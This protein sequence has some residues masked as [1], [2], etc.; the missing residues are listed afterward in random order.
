MRKAFATLVIVAAVVLGT[1]GVAAAHPQDEDGHPGQARGFGSEP[2][3]IGFEHADASGQAGLFQ[4]FVV[5][6]P[7]C[8][9]H[10]SFH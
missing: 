5:H 10:P 7:T 3:L 2:A 9:G 1:T 8:Q 4:G 6:A